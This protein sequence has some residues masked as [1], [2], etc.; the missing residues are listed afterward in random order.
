M[1]ANIKVFCRLRP[2][3]NLEKSMGGKCCVDFTDKR[4]QV[5]V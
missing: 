2:L 5:K 3:N 4:I 1:A